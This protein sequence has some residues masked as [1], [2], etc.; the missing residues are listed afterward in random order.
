MKRKRRPLKMQAPVAGRM[1]PERMKRV[2]ILNLLLISYRNG[3]SDFF[4]SANVPEAVS[5]SRFIVAQKAQTCADG[6][7]RGMICSFR[8]CPAA[9]KR[10]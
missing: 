8:L 2:K 4:D 5:D 6:K 1:K 9:F 3:K 7:W 10:L